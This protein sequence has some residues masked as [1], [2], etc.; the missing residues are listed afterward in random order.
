MRG[1]ARL[2]IAW[3]HAHD[4]RGFGMNERAPPSPPFIRGFAHRS[5]R[6]RRPESPRSGRTGPGLRTTGFATHAE[7]QRSGRSAD[8]ERTG[9]SDDGSVVAATGPARRMLRLQTNA[10]VVRISTVAKGSIGTA[11]CYICN[12]RNHRCTAALQSS[13]ATETRAEMPWL[14]ATQISTK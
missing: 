11:V 8:G 1:R 6:A 3:L 4:L 13:L 12:Q 7:S 10:S 2:S 14:H 9:A 5:C